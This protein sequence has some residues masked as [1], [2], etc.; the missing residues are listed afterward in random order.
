MKNFPE[1]YQEECEALA[2][3]LYQLIAPPEPFRVTVYAMDENQFGFRI[4]EISIHTG[5]AGSSFMRNDASVHALALIL[6]TEDF[7]RSYRV[8]AFRPAGWQS[9]LDAHADAKWK[10]EKVVKAL[11]RKA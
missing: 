10:L 9:D 11:E 8:K 4:H 6:A 7:V 2:K 3:F 5:V 1:K